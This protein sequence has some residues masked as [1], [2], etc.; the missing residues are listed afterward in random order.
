MGAVIAYLIVTIL[1]PTQEKGQREKGYYS[2]FTERE[3]EAQ[4]YV[5]INNRTKAFYHLTA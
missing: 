2:H 3:T 1:I 4:N 5:N